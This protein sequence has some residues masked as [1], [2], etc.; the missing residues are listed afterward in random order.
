MA[1][2]NSVFSSNFKDFTIG[3]VPLLYMYEL[4]LKHDLLESAGGDMPPGSEHSSTSARQVQYPQPRK[5]RKRADS[6]APEWVDTV[7]TASAQ[8]LQI[9][10]SADQQRLH[11]FSAERMKVE[12]TRSRVNLSADLES[13]LQSVL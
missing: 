3:N 6:P 5:V 8:P 1:T 4:F 11:F 2:S 7:T 9:Q 10:R 12:A 13:S